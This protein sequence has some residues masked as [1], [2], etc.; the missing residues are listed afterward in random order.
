MPPIIARAGPLFKYLSIYPYNFEHIM[1]FLF[2]SKEL[3][4]LS[5]EKKNGPYNLE[6]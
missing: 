6:T 2:A 1:W 5:K 4:Q 3:L